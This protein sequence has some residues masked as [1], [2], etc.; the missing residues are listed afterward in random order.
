MD[1]GGPAQAAGMQP[2]DVITR[3]DGT[4]VDSDAH[5][6]LMVRDVRPGARVAV[7][8]MRDARLLT[9]NLTVGSQ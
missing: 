2:Q 7:E 3:S 9:V 1:A 6:T 5:L 4:P 8:L